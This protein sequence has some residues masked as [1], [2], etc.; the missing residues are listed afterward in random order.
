M[1]GGARVAVLV[2]AVLACVPAHAQNKDLEATLRSLNAS[3]KEA[4]R[5][6]DEIEK[7]EASL[8]QLREKA[9]SHARNVQRAERAASKAD[10]QLA[11][12]IQALD[13]AQAKY[14]AQRESYTEALRQLLYMRQLPPTAF[15]G[16]DAH[17]A[18][19]VR[20]AGALKLAERTLATR[21]TDMKRTVDTLELLK[22]RLV[23]ERNQ[24]KARKKTLS[25]AQKELSRDLKLRQKLYAALSTDHEETLRRV[26]TLA[27]QSRDL[28]DL[29]DRLD[30][31]NAGK[32]TKTTRKGRWKP[33]VQGKVLHKFGERKSANDH[34]RGVVL[35]ARS[36]GTVIAPSAGKVVF[37]GPFRDYGNMVL[38]R[39]DAKHISLLAGLGGV[40][41]GLNQEVAAGEPIGRM[42]T[43]KTPKLYMELRK[44]GKTIDP[45]VW[46]AK[47][48]A[49]I[50]T[51]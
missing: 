23:E 22:T 3:Q 40:D 5:L 44:S 31:A 20:T 33:P 15:F 19:M 34:Y 30:K 18:S 42:A 41:V 13:S 45:S 49:N 48:G 38:L 1:R 46:Y 8:E 12:T 24:S 28:G 4:S 43:A 47:L 39:H 16:D 36:G 11:A 6:K 26:E 9:T 27:K 32:P 2:A 25:V 14:H 7:T 51:N 17:V 29:I 50:A 37:T 35:A 10:K 21:A